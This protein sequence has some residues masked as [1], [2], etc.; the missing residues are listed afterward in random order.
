MR[1]R[2]WRTCQH[3]NAGA[4][5]EGAAHIHSARGSRARLTSQH[6]APRP[7]SPPRAAAARRSRRAA[8]DPAAGF[9]GAGRSR[10]LPSANESQRRGKCLSV[11]PHT[12]STHHRARQQPAPFPRPERTSA[13]L[14]VLVAS[15]REEE[16]RG[17]AAAGRAR[18]RPLAAA[19]CPS[20][21]RSSRSLWPAAQSPSRCTAR[22][23]AGRS[24]SSRPTPASEARVAIRIIFLLSGT[25]G[26]G[27]EDHDFFRKVA[28]GF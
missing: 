9:L 10:R 21:S 20:P 1:A 18:G 4:G 23:W 8:A 17:R 13:R 27:E 14:H 15:Q 22:G 25:R 26:G 24:Y 12:P 7:R 11:D 2:G 6:V 5:R 3:V 19:H 28:S 16:V